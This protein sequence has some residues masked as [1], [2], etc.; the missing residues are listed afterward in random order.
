[1]PS[2]LQLAKADIVELFAAASS[3]VYTSKQLAAVLAQHRRGWRLPDSTRALEF[4]AF[5]RKHG[6]LRRRKLRSG[7][8][9][10]EIT[11]YIWGAASAH[12]VALSLKPHAYL[13][14]G[15]AAALHGL[16]KLKRKTVYLNAEQSK[17]PPFSGVLTQQGIDRAFA[18]NQRSSQLVYSYGAVSIVQLAG[19]HTSCLGVEELNGTNGEKLTVTNLERTLIDMVVRPTY[20]GG[21]SELLKAYRAAKS[22]ISMQYLLTI[23]RK[24]AHAYPYHQSI[25]FLMERTGY[26]KE[27]YEQL[28]E[29][30]LA[31]DFYLEHRMH[32]P[33]YSPEWRLYFPSPSR[34]RSSQD[35]D[36]GAL[37]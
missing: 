23:L 1:M 27:S 8:Y 3:N 17:K 34:A 14:H 10:H 33:V 37:E 6:D 30:G 5:L 15:T 7:T 21:M 12:E 13:S 29:L 25:G 11:R 2:R 19:K 16:T 31:H 35:A 24:L 32:E 36:A 20:A 18:G 22:R 26:P 28:R 4:I 9:S